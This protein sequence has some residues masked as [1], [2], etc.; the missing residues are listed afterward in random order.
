[1]IGVS[2]LV[3]WFPAFAAKLLPGWAFNIAMIIHSDE[4][5]LATGFIFA[6]HF[7]NSHLRPE[8]FP[9]DFVIFT[10]R[11]HLDEL[12]HERPLEYER[13]VASGEL[14]KQMGMHVLPWQYKASRI[15]GMIALVRRADPAGADALGRL[16]HW[17]QSRYLSRAERRG[18]FGT[19]AAHDVAP[20]LAFTA[21]G[22]F[23]AAASR[24]P[25]RC[26]FPINSKKRSVSTKRKKVS[27]ER[28]VARRG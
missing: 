8:K 13:L 19:A 14:E 25:I 6:I 3:L 24:R 11:V 1:M 7:F 28:A 10:G 5:I 20:C 12:K 22:Q 18:L 27:E 16:F 15:F 26:R 17:Q 21:S 9:M 23:S 2:G 4:A